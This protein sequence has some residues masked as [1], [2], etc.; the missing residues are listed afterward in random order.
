MVRIKYRYL[1]VNI[2][3]P[4]P[5]T[6][7]TKQTAASAKQDLHYTVQFR[8]PSSDQLNARLLARLVRDGVAD[9]F[10]DYGS[11]MVASSLVGTHTLERPRAW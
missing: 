11:G 4:E 5:A 6:G 1:L 3:Y 10:G 8:Q 9:L 2:L 7:A